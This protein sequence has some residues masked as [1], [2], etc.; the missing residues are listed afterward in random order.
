M[1]VC[2]PYKSYRLNIH[3]FISKILSFFNEK[4]L[5]ERT[6]LYEHFSTNKLSQSVRTL[7][8]F[9]NAQTLTARTYF[10]NIFQRKLSQSVSTSSG[11]GSGRQM[12][13]MKAAR[14]TVYFGI[15]IRDLA[16]VSE[17]R[18]WDLAEI[19][20]GNHHQVTIRG[21]RRVK[22]RVHLF[23]T[24]SQFLLEIF[25]QCSGRDTHHREDG[26]RK[27]FRWDFGSPEHWEGEN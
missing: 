1:R 8:T 5:T 6:L 18:D 12:K 7:W 2:T 24:S 9:F 10:M 26:R 4:T 13:K 20:R 3:H 21:S 17:F 19:R 27:L 25:P 22:W 14:W 11:S 23:P 15:E 16:K